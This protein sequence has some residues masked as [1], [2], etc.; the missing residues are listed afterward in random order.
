[1][2]V[3][4]QNPSYGL[5]GNTAMQSDDTTQVLLIR[6]G[7]QVY[8]S[9]DQILV[10]LRSVA[11]KWAGDPWPAPEAAA[12]ISCANDLHNLAYRLDAACTELAVQEGDGI[13]I[14]PPDPAGLP[15]RV[16]FS[17]VCEPGRAVEVA[18][19][20]DTRARELSAD[21]GGGI[22]PA[23]A[24]YSGPPLDDRGNTIRSVRL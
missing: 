1:M 6:S 15:V 23:G 10:L 13:R 12:V 19:A 8:M 22:V 17:V 16:S 2:L 20:L 14:Q 9:A 21:L 24:V 4:F 18:A 5:K 7:E 3:L 11:E